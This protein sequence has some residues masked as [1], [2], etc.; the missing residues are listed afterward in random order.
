[1]MIVMIMIMIMIIVMIVVVVIT[2]TMILIM[3]RITIMDRGVSVQAVH[4][5]VG[6]PRVQRDGVS[7][8]QPR[9]DPVLE[10]TRLARD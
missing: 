5:A 6:R 1:M 4:E 3:I 8:A 10:V 7:P 2:I 9:G